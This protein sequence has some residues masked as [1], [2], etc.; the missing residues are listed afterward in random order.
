[1]S[2]NSPKISEILMEKAVVA[3]KEDA[4]LAES[5]KLNFR[6]IYNDDRQIY[7]ADLPNS[8]DF[9]VVKVR[10]VQAV[11]ESDH[12]TADLRQE[13]QQLTDAWQ[14]ASQMQQGYSMSRP[15]AIWEEE[16]AILLTGCAG[17]NLNDVFNQKVLSWTF[18][19][20][21]LQHAI[22]GCGKWLGNYHEYSCQNGCFQDSIDNRTSH[23]QR[24]LTFLKNKNSGALHVDAL[25]EIE[26]RFLSLVNDASSGRIGLV[27]GNFAYRNVLFSPTQINLV[28]FEDAHIEHAAYDIGQF[29]AEILFKSQFPWLRHR[30]Q[31]LLSAFR[32]GYQ[33]N[34]AIEEPILKAYT[35]YHLLVHL[36]ELSTRRTPKIPHRWLLN[37]RIRYLAQLLKQWL[38]QTNSLR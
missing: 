29:M 18:D 2:S 22:S 4:S 33:E 24:M 20:T 37:F 36:Y 35:G 3:I 1:M 7:R 26:A 8:S 19:I 5:V 10:G 11:K 27:H 23:F 13:Y 31:G 6:L 30:T 14:N 16:K 38:N 25:N 9:Y 28:D 15:L 32:K 34:T 21:R 12:D 17:D